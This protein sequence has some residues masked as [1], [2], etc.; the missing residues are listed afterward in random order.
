MH[1]G[2]RQRSRPEPSAPPPARARTFQRATV[3]TAVPSRPREWTWFVETFWKQRKYTYRRWRR[4][5]APIPYITRIAQYARRGA[6]DSRG[7]A[8]RERSMGGPRA[9]ARRRAV[10]R[11]DG[12]G[13]HPSRRDVERPRSIRA[14]VSQWGMSWK[15][16][17]ARRYQRT[18]Q[19]IARDPSGTA[20]IQREK[21]EGSARPFAC[22]RGRGLSGR[23]ACYAKLRA[24]W[25]RRPA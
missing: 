18:L 5:P 10:F 3:S 8:R 15:S 23:C 13:P 4:G 7:R 14:A 11:F 24:H 25:N 6:F 9:G 17:S 22:R 21:R 19:L 12:R 1:R 20:S 16:R 2:H